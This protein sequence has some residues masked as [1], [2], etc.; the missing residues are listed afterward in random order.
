MINNPPLSKALKGDYRYCHLLKMRFDWGTVYM[1]DADEDIRYNGAVYLAGMFK[2]VGTV[3]QSGGIRIG[4]MKLSFNALA[5]SVVALGLQ[6]KWMNRHVEISKLII[7]TSPVGHLHLYSGLLSKMRLT[8]SGSLSFTV[9]SI[10]ADFEKTAGR[11]TNTASH[12]KY[13]PSTDPFEHTAFLDDSIPWGKAGDGKVRSKSA[14]PRRSDY[15]PPRNKQG[16][17]EEAP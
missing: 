15:E 5:P 1:T 2:S 3:K 7:T 13:Y 11:Q 17:Q 4:D 12:Q 8:T 10:W 14:K 16:Q 9:S 6:E